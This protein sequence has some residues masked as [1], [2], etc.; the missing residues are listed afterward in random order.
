MHLRL[1]TKPTSLLPKRERG[2]CTELARST[3]SG[4]WGDPRAG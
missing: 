1:E 4:L 2:D 3:P